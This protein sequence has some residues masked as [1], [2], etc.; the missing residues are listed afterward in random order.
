M[1]L[2]HRPTPPLDSYL[3][4][5]WYYDGY[6]AEQHKERVLPDGRFQLIIDLTEGPGVVTGIRS[7]YIVIDAAA[8]HSVMGVVFW[9]GGARAFFAS[10]ADEFA[11]HVVTLDLVWGSSV[12]GLRERLRE[13]LSSAAK[14]SVL[15]A[16]L[17]M[18]LRKRLELHPAVRYG[19]KEFQRGPN[20]RRVLDVTQEAGLSRRRFA[21]L[22]RE[23]VGTTPKA[24]CRIHRFQRV[25]QQIA[26]GAPVDWADV[27]LA[28]GYSDQAHLAHE[29]HEFS[30]LSP[31][32]FLATDRPF[33]NH[34]RMD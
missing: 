22:F 21:Q 29:F 33:A 28:S 11:N 32:T 12:G 2:V 18:R 4:S 5:L 31:S 14:F 13:A 19:L 24:F 7:H 34:L 25:V 16:A 27:A 20:V 30:G 3:E 23:Q 10:P 8:I 9:P 6:V 26:S 1:L 17:Q 15:E